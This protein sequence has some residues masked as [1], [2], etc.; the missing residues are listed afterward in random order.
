MTFKYLT[1]NW[2]SIAPLQGSFKRANSDGLCPSL[3][4]FAPSGLMKN[5]QY[6]PFVFNAY[7][8]VFTTTAFSIEDFA[9]KENSSD[10]LKS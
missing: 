3:E 4:Y 6:Y 7:D 5:I 10:S 1:V 2:T 8:G 9:E